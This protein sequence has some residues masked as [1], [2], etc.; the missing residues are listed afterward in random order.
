MSRI[1]QLQRM[2]DADQTDA[3]IPYMI[4]QEHVS[5]GDHQASIAWFDRCLTLDAEYHY[6]YFHKARALDAIG[7]DEEAVIAASAGLARARVAGHQKAVDEL[8]G[9]VEMLEG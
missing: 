8:A 5:A 9:L 4:A 6:A 3:D 2:W 1:E 7:H